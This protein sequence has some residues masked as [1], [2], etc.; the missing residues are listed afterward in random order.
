MK[1]IPLCTFTV[2]GLA[3]GKYSE[4]EAAIKVDDVVWLRPDPQNKFDLKAVAVDY[5]NTGTGKIKHIGWIPAKE[6]AAKSM[7]FAMLMQDF[8][9]QGRVTVHSLNV[10]I[11]DRLTIE[12]FID[13]ENDAG[14]D[15]GA[16]TTPMH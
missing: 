9:I 1:T 13:L 10:S 12:V 16:P 3:H 14:L 8:P 2:T 5:P 11:Y 7:L 6:A 4:V 15:Q